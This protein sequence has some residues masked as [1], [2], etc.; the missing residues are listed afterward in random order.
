MLA[1]ADTMP[2]LAIPAR[3]RPPS[4][5]GWLPAEANDLVRELERGWDLARF[6]RGL[7]EYL[8][9]TDV[10]CARMDW[11]R[12]TAWSTS[13]P[14]SPRLQEL[15]PEVAGSGRRIVLPNAILEPIGIAPA[16]GAL[17]VKGAADRVLQTH[18]L[19]LIARIAARIAPVLEAG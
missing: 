8:G 17:V 4:A 6:E 18:T 16:F 3:T 13:G 7:A 9:A 2:T 10:L 11:A 15:V 1:I 14:V 19:R 12:R 5:R